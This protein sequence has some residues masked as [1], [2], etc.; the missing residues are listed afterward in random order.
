MRQFFVIRLLC[1]GV[2]TIA[3]IVYVSPA[4]RP[5]VV[6]QQTTP[7]ISGATTLTVS[8]TALVEEVVT[9]GGERL[10]CVAHVYD[11]RHFLDLPLECA[12]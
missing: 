9:P 12:R 10:L 8:S 2:L 7:A 1:L 4:P 5:S 11:G 6:V 3:V